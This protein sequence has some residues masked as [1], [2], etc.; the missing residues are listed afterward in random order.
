M[1]LYVAV[2]LDNNPAHELYKTAKINQNSLII[3]QF[4]SILSNNFYL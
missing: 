1:S 4:I 3:Y 2:K